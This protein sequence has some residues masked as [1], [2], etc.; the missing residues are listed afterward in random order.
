M[1]TLAQG[2]LPKDPNVLR[3]IV[4]HNEGNAGVLATV[5]QGGRIKQGDAVN[6]E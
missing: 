3:T 5:V 1:T 2:D 6:L 4:Q